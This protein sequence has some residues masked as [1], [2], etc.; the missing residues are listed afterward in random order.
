[1]PA[2]NRRS[3]RQPSFF[4]L[5]C[6]L[7][8]LAGCASSPPPS[9]G[10]TTTSGTGTPTATATPT[11]SVKPPPSGPGTLQGASWDALPGWR[12]DNPV[13]AWPAFIQSCQKIR[14]RAGW[15][16][17]CDYAL[18]LGAHPPSET[19][20]QF[21]ENNF[22]PWVVVNADG[23]RQGMVTGY[24]EPLIQGSR[25]SSSRYR[26]PVHAVPN[27]ILSVE[28]SRAAPELK[29]KDLRGRLEGSKV[30]PYW[31]RGEIN[32]MGNRF[33]AT[34]L[35]W[36]EEPIELFFLHVQGSGQL[37]LP[38]GQRM[39]IGFADKNGYPY[40]SIGRWLVQQGELTL[41]QASME[42]IKR[43]ARANPSRLDELLAVNESYIFFREMPAGNSGPVGAL[44]VP[45]TAGRS[46]AVDRKTIPLGAPVFLSTSEPLSQRPLNRLMMAQDTGSAIVG[47]VRA[48][49]FWGFGAEAGAQAG[50]MRQAGQMWVLL[51]RG[52]R[53]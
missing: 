12:Q 40:T 5:L 25:V 1:M 31:T 42:G 33:P 23:T 16:A 46:I 39:R 43:W 8:V 7:L 24:Y 36:A 15:Q 50:K 2:P 52:M 4:G 47:A 37:Q 21:F 44:S 18:R 53:P 6:A 22:Q 10:A 20:R 51:P 30:V 41:A 35:A 9:D 19:V 38:D 13:E 3:R 32:A 45:L 26:Y 11:S 29:G 34:V 17:V 27:D 28:M 48:D 14:L 49:Y